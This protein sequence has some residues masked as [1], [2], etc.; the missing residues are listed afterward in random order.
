MIST[1]VLRY[2]AL[3]KF[4]KLNYISIPKE[5][6]RH[7]KAIQTRFFSL[8]SNYC[9]FYVSLDSNLDKKAL[10]FYHFTCQ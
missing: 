8:K 9:I 4:K 3:F 2:K 6:C 7:Y 5:V 10:F 1:K